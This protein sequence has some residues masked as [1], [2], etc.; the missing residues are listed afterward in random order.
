MKKKTETT[1]EEFYESQGIG[2]TEL[3]RISGV[4]KMTINNYKTVTKSNHVV[5]FDKK[6]GDFEIV[7]T[8]K[9]MARGNVGSISKSPIRKKKI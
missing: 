3:A 9:V 5:R 7:R 2:P 4:N 8:E 1:I 6:T